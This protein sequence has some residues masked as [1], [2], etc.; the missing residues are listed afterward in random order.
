MVTESYERKVEL[1]DY[2]E[3]LL[4]RKVLILSFA[5]ISGLAAGLNSMDTPP[6]QYVSEALIVVAQP[7]ASTGS[8]I[9][10]SGLSPQTYEALA[11]SDELMQSVRD[12]LLMME[13]DSQVSEYIAITSLESMASQLT[14]KLVKETQ[15]TGSTPVLSFRA[16]SSVEALPVPLVNA[17]TE[18]FVER[19]RGLSSNVADSYY[20]WVEGQF[21]TATA[22]LEQT[23]DQLRELTMSNSDLSILEAEIKIKTSRLDSALT[24]YQEFE[25]ELESKEREFEFIQS[26][27]DDVELNH[28][29]L[30]YADLKQLPTRQEAVRGPR[31]RK[32]LVDLRHDVAAGVTD[33]LQLQ[34]RHDR[35]RREYSAKTRSFLLL[36]E[37]R[38]R[39]ERQRRRAALLESQLTAFRQEAVQ[40]DQDIKEVGLDLEVYGKNLKLEPRV[41][42]EAKAILDEELW[43]R[44]ADRGGVDERLQKALGGYRL[45]SESLNSKHQALTHEMRDMQIQY[46]RATAQ[47]SFI[48]AEIP[49]LEEDLG[50]VRTR[51][52]S[53]GEL[54][55]EELHKLD[56]ERVALEDSLSRE[57]HPL[58]ERLGFERNSLQ[59]QRLEY[60]TMREREEHL[61][62]QI[63]M[64]TAKVGFEK[65]GFQRWSAQLQEQRIHVDSLARARRRLVREQ[66]VSQKT[67]DRFANLLEEARIARVQAAGDIQI[68]SPAVVSRPVP[69]R[70]TSK[71]PVFGAIVGLVASVM[72]AFLLEYVEGARAR[73]TVPRP[74]PGDPQTA[75]P[76]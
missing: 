3:V 57:A 49:V 61:S 34:E 6:G 7:I 47:I 50:A 26:Q 74:A 24:Q 33:S 13:L 60:I 25:A 15:A 45:V 8:E 55:S 48:E 21:A 31:H 69:W 64:L 28:E 53:L 62:W 73:A 9:T 76:R 20:Q 42:Y 18:L 65:G 51:L 40:L 46:D 75:P 19:H 17:W 41:N 71:G 16:R 68:V 63:T 44:A 22:N 29:W 32:Q 14:A 67:V 4:K 54:E 23:E 38:T 52:D 2:I 58:H 39:I 72:L 10:V 43:E 59:A 36:F 12:T 27:L 5:A 56:R 11:K 70:G 37:R 30:G 66:D 1:I 35:R